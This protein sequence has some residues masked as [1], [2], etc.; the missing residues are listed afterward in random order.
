MRARSLKRQRQD[1]RDKPALEHY[2]QTHSRCLLCWAQFVYEEP[3][4]LLLHHIAG[5]NG[6]N[7]NDPSNVSMVCPP[8]HRACHEG[9]ATRPSLQVG[10]VITAK[11][12]EDVWADVAVIHRLRNKRLIEPLPLP[13]F[14][15]RERAKNQCGA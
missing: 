10:H 2:A 11:L 3:W 13:E 4:R 5:R 14:Y 12:I 8:C 15:L 7:F 6:A 9:D 1:R